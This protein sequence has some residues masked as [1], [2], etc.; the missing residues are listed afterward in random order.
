MAIESYEIVT[1]HFCNGKVRE[2]EE[3]FAVVDIDEEDPMLLIDIEAVAVATE[4]SD[5][6]PHEEET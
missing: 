5:I 6:Y 1:P 4:G 2:A 3:V